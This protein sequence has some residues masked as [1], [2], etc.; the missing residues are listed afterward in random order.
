MEDKVLMPRKL[1]AENGAKALLSGEFY[2]EIEVTCHECGGYG[3]DCD[4]DSDCL[5]CNGTG[6][7]N[8]RISVSWTTIKAVYKTAVKYLGKELTEYAAQDLSDK[9]PATL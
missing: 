2:E 5:V 1:T 4:G 8:Q 7:Y 9:T 6:N 3:L